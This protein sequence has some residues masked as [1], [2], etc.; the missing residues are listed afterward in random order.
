MGLRRGWG[1]SFIIKPLSENPDMGA[2]QSVSKKWDKP[3]HLC[4]NERLVGPLEARDYRQ[5]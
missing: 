1:I 3:H 4:P 5:V 2:W